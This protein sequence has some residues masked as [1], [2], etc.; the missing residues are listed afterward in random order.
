LPYEEQTPYR[1]AGQIVR[2]V[3][4]IF[5]NDR[6]DVAR[7]KLATAVEELFPTPEATEATRY[8]SLLLGLGLDAPPDQAIHLLFTMRMLV[9]HLAQREP[10]LLVFEDVHWADDALLDLIDYLVS[11]V[12]DA[13]VVVLALARPEFLETRR[14]WGGGMVGQT[15]LPLEAISD[16][17]SKAV[18]S[19]I[20]PGTA[21]ATIERVVSVAEGN[22]LFLEELVASVADDVSNEELP[23]TVR[24]AIAARID[25][26]PGPA[27]TALLHASVIGPSFWRGVL[28]GIGE[29]E[30]VDE[31]LDGLEERGLILRRSQ[32]QIEGDVEFSFKHV[33]IRDVAYELLARADRRERHAR[34]AQFFE[35]RTAELGEAAAALARHWRDAGDPERALGYFI[36]AGEQA[37]RGWA[38]D[39]AAVLYKEALDLV[40]DGDGA[41]L[42]DLRRRLALARAAAVHIPDARQLMR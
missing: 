2:N 16:A 38:K 27:R 3:A 12:R 24:A 22:P 36:R 9:E 14:T 31:A 23:P 21:D 6:V 7:S 29:L 11:H 34:V 10:V 42:T 25:A 35:E 13:R 28:S 33:L 19:A 4:G 40:P 20:L 8:L 17:D 1:A 32:S 30:A 39:Q 18:A 26:L 41:Q 37:E 5:E 15:T